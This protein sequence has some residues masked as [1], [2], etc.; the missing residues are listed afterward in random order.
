MKQC[1]KCNE[2]FT[3]NLSNYFHKRANSPD[4]LQYVCKR[5]I[6][7]AHATHYLD[8]ID[9]YKEKALKHNSEYRLR[10]LQFVVDYFKTNPCTDCGETDPVVLEFDHLGNKQY[11]IAELQHASLDTLKQEI[12][13]CE[14]R[15]ANC[16]RRKTAKQFNYYKDISL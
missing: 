15:C 11:N 14:V 10:N 1:T 13:K 16:H 4:G 3:E 5:C 2:T 9:Y 12:A 6:R 7:Q 8:N